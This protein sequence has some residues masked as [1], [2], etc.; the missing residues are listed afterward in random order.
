MKRAFQ[1]FKRD[2]RRLARNPIAMIVVAGVCL[3][4]SLY[5]WFNIAANMDPYGNT[6]SVQIA[7]A[8]LDQGT[9]NEL[10]GAL[11]AGEEVV[12]QLK[13]NHALGWKFVGEEKAVDGVKSGKYYAAIVI[14]EDFSESLTSVLTGTIEQPKVYLLFK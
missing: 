6:G 2:M 7:V 14:P 1:I 8:N 10:T 4:P 3:L 13:E 5:A 9:D 11:N 12:K